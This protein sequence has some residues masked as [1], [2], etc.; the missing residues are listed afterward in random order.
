MPKR[1]AQVNDYCVACG[2]CIAVCP[3]SA[4]S[5]WRGII[6]QV[7]LQ[8]CVGCGKCAAECPAGAIEIKNREA[9]Q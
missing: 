2:T 5:V 6:A 8:R 4:I 3:L 1:F 7:D 9:A